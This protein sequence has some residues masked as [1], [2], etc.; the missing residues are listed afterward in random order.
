[1]QRILIHIP[2]EHYD[3][4]VSRCDPWTRHYTIL[5]N[6]IIHR[7]PNEDY[8]EIYCTAHEAKGLLD[9]AEH[10]YPKVAPHIKDAIAGPRDS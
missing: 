9:S 7:R 10:V 1:M 8:A 2:R 5:K 4:F 6:A 3:G